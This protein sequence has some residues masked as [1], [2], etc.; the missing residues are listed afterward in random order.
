MKKDLGRSISFLGALCGYISGQLQRLDL[1]G[2]YRIRASVIL[3]AGEFYIEL[4]RYEGP[5]DVRI[6]FD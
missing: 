1:F 6:R 5:P 3:R 2:A 4:G